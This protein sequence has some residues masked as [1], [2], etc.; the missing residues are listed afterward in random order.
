MQCATASVSGSDGAFPSNQTTA[1]KPM[2]ASSRRTSD[3]YIEMM[4]ELHTVPDMSDQFVELL[5]GM[6]NTKLTA[7]SDYDNR[8][9]VINL[10]IPTANN[11]EI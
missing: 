2:A 5:S 7:A 11:F 9:I 3:D 6:D 8:V 4:T 10:G 1:T